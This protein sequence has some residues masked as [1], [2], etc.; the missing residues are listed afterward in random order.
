MLLWVKADHFPKLGDT[1]FGGPYNEDYTLMGSMFGGPLFR[2]TT[3][4]KCLGVVYPRL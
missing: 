3:M 4:K 1:L 2:E